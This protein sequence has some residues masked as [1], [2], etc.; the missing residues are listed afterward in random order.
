MGT[1][2]EQHGL[3]PMASAVGLARAARGIPLRGRGGVIRAFAI[4][5]PDVFAD[6]G[7]QRWN[8]HPCGYPVRNVGGRDSRQQ[9]RLSRV[10]MDLEPGDP[11]EVDHINGDKLDNRRKNLRITTRAQNAQNFGSRPGS[12]SK[13]RGVTWHKAAGKWMAQHILN[14][15]RH[16][17]GLFEDE[18]DAGRAAAEWRAA[19]MPYA[20][21]RGGPPV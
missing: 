14:G 2:L 21:D 17:L 6:L 5:D 11:R 13:Y 19:N 10:I 12:S 15:E 20:T 3:V 1:T 9:L 16:Y 4:V 18:D 8:L 7:D